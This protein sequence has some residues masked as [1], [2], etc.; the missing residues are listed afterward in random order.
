M[1]F[2]LVKDNSYNSFNLGEWKWDEE[3][4]EWVFTPDVD[5]VKLPRT[6]DLSSIGV[7][8]IILALVVFCVAFYFS[9]KAGKAARERRINN[10]ENSAK[11]RK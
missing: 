8:G 3:R 9:S 7:E 2:G 6:S 5:Y 4:G 10:R 11:K 1:L